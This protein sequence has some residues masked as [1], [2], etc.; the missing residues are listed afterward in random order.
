[1]GHF[2]EQQSKSSWGVIV[3]N[4]GEKNEKRER[5]LKC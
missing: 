1:M 3:Q 4:E 5:E 2:S